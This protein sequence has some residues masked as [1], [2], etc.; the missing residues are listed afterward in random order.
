MERLGE[1]IVFLCVMS[2]LIFWGGYELVDWLFI[3]DA[4]RSTTPI[5]P[6]IELVVKDNVVDTVYVYRQP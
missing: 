1:A 6:E 4:I 5:T 2:V 3:D